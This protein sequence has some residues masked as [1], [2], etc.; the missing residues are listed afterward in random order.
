MGAEG[1]WE[2]FVPSVGNSC[3]LKNLKMLKNKV[4]QINIYKVYINK[5]Y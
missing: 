4:Y 5:N 2:Q 3:D 1:I